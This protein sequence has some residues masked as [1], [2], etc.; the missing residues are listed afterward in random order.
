MKQHIRSDFEVT[1]ELS[2]A[3]Y[4]NESHYSLPTPRVH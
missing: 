1:D 2:A 4:G 3:T